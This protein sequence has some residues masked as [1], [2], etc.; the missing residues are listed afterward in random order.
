MA[1]A[2]GVLCR[3]S[4]VIPSIRLWPSRYGLSHAPRGTARDL[5]LTYETVY[6]PPA[7]VLLHDL[8]FQIPTE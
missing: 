3:L 1:A 6:A 4:V 7:T 2:A 5:N 8:Q